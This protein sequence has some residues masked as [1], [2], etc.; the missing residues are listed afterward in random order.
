MKVFDQK[1]TVTI[2]NKLGR[3]RRPF[4]FVIS[5]DKEENHIVE[6]EEIEDSPFHLQFKTPTSSIPLHIEVE[7]LDFTTYQKAFDYVH[8]QL[9][10]GNSFLTNLTASTRIQGPELR[11]IFHSA[12]APFKLMLE[13][14]WVCFTPEKFVSVEPNGLLSTFP[15]KGTKVEIGAHA[16]RELLEDPKELFEHT[17]IVDLL[18]NDLSQISSEVHV[19]RFRYIEPINRSDGSTLLQMS[20]EITAK[21]GPN[22]NETLGEWFFKLLPAGS[23]CGAPKAETLKIIQEAEKNLH[24]DGKRGFYTG[25]AGIYDGEQLFS[26]VLIRFIEKT[27]DGLIFKSGGGITFKSEVVKEY[28]EILQKIYIP[29]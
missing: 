24:P 21:L 1:D 3:E 11:E 29:L 20:S 22:W 9:L 5:Y 12:K 14:R 23:I 6:W 17:T 2:M 26:Y 18:R 10:E 16:E 28:E 8:G 7:P 27:R 19:R 13:D 25:V 15:M 4:L